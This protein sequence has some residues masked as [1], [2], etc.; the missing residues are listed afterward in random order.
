M[1]RS[2]A[3]YYIINLVVVL[4]TT[5]YFFGELNGYPVPI[6]SDDAG[7]MTTIR[8]MVEYGM[9]CPMGILSGKYSIFFTL[10]RILYL[11]FGATTYATQ[12]AFAIRFFLCM[13][14]TIFLINC[15]DEKKVDWVSMLFLCYMVVFPKF[16]ELYKG[17][18]SFKYH[19]DPTIL[20]LF[21]VLFYKKYSQSKKMQYFWGIIICLLVSLLTGDVL[22]VPF[23]YIPIFLFIQIK[24]IVWEKKYIF[25]KVEG[26]ILAMAVVMYR[27]VDS[28]MG[29]SGF[30]G[31]GSRC[32]VE[33]NEIGG[34]IA[35]WVKGVVSLFNADIEG[36][37]MLS[38]NTI[39]SGVKLLFVIVMLGC[40]VVSIWNAMCKKSKNEV[41]LLLS[42]SVVS[43]SLCFILTT[44]EFT[45]EEVARYFN[46]V[47]FALPLV[48]ISFFKD[49]INKEDNNRR[50]VVVVLLLLTASVYHNVSFTIVDETQSEVNS[51]LA[52]EQL[53]NGIGNFWSANILSMYSDYAIEVQPVWLDGTQIK[54]MHNEYKNYADKSNLC[55]FVIL[56]EEMTLGIDKESMVGLY[57]VPQKDIS[58]EDREVLIYD[59][60]LRAIPLQL[61]AVDFQ[62]KNGDIIIDDNAICIRE[63]VKVESP[64]IDIESGTLEIKIVGE[65]LDNCIIDIADVNK[66]VEYKEISRRSDEI[67]IE[68]NSYGLTSIYM[69]L[70]NISDESYISEV[71][72][73]YKQIGYVVEDGINSDNGEVSVDLED[74]IYKLVFYGDNID[75]INISEDSD[76]YEKTET[77][78]KRVA[79]VIEVENGNVQLG[80]DTK[81][82]VNRISIENYDSKDNETKLYVHGLVCK[83]NGANLQYSS[84]VE[85]KEGN[86]LCVP[87]GEKVYGP[88]ISIDKGTYLISGYGN[89]KDCDLSITYNAGQDFLK[90]EIVELTDAYFKIEVNLEEPVDLFEVVIQSKNDN[91]VLN[92]YSILENNYEKSSL[93]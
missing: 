20:F 78:K 23:I 81:G 52:N 16:D 59:F 14:P 93:N 4:I 2:K 56:D 61:L 27:I 91:T 13:L 66:A 39:S 32:I 24:F 54:P 50:A 18:T 38:F 85:A 86:T 84:G 80:Y 37:N 8:N 71:T 3:K 11:L 30:S 34:N 5:I 65:N 12:L 72:M 79:Y 49:R 63:G 83:C 64:Q 46:V 6:H 25:A 55:N 57:G 29:Q 69:E 42:L 92:G 68:L 43:S 17:I 75:D 1:K 44:T 40:V 74:G 19:M 47:I 26:I 36:N 60:D 82:S 77:G 22:V 35:L 89:I 28:V 73:A 41:E 58:I 87:N 21:I 48:M 33:V 31:Y 7:T 53:K 51:T 9:E 10:N 45:T 15:D 88:Y 67:V 90:Y 70:K 62:A 76:N